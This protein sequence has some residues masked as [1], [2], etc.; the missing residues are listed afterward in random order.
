[1][2]AVLGARYSIPR[3]V[4]QLAEVVDQPV[5]LDPRRKRV[6]LAVRGLLL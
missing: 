2:V 4:W 3:R 5:G 1:M 6:V